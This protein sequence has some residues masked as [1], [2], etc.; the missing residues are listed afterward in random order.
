MVALKTHRI[1][2]S[3]ILMQIAKSPAFSQMK[4]RTK[5][6]FEVSTLDCLFLSVV[7]LKKSTDWISFTHVCQQN[8]CRLRA[9]SHW[10]ECNTSNIL[11]KNNLGEIAQISVKFLHGL[12]REIKPGDISSSVFLFCLWFPVMVQSLTPF[13][14]D[15]R[16]QNCMGGANV[17]QKGK[18]P[19]RRFKI[20]ISSK[21]E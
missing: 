1:R 8:T 5:I 20:H 9:E 13:T 10:N 14:A 3:V 2:H 19:M 16:F 17:N 4:H 12:E 21:G 6:I 7:S 18:W 15:C 11:T